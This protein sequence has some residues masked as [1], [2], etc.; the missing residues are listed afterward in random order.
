VRRSD[1]QAGP[2]KAAAR[3]Y[4][5]LLMMCERCEEFDVEVDV[6]GP[7][8]QRRIMEKAHLAGQSQEQGLRGRAPD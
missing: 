1:A 8:Q 2:G 6:H 3:E 4:L 5:D 7:A